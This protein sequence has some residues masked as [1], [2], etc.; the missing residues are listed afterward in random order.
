MITVKHNVRSPSKTT[1]G[2]VN[3]GETFTWND[4]VYIKLM[5]EIV[6]N[7]VWCF[8]QNRFG[9]WKS[10]ETIDHIVDCTLAV[11]TYK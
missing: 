6:P 7:N 2:A 3:I 4:L 10:E 9:Y 5:S 11:T 1:F 8:S